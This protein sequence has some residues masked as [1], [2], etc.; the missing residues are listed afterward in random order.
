MIP[1]FRIISSDVVRVGIGDAMRSMDF[2]SALA[3]PYAS[4]P[5]STSR[6]AGRPSSA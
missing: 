2:P 3:A 6:K 4:K 5:G 1:M